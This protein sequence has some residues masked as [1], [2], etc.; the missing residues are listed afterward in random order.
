MGETSAVKILKKRW[1]DGDPERVKEIEAERG[2]G[3]MDRIL[4]MVEEIEAIV[5]DDKLS[6]LGIRIEVVKKC[7]QISRTIDEVIQTKEG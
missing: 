2:R 3:D 5:Y 7:L 1:L 4:K 6:L